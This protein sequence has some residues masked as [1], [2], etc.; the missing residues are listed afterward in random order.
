MVGMQDQRNIHDMGRI[1]IG[2]TTSEHVQEVGGVRRAR[3]WRHWLSPMAYALP[4]RHNRWEEGCQAYGPLVI[5]FGGA[6]AGIGIEGCQGG[7]R[8]TYYIHRQGCGG[9]EAHQ[10]KNRSG[11]CALRVQLLC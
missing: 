9:K 10:I 11:Q 8:R 6:I 2:Y 1:G 7:D 5:S 3:Q 4:T